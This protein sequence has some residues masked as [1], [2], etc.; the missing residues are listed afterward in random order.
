MGSILGQIWVALP[1]SQLAGCHRPDWRSLALVQEEWR[2]RASQLTQRC[3]DLVS[4]AHPRSRARSRSATTRSR[5]LGR[6]NELVSHGGA[7]VLC[8]V[9]AS[10][11][12][13]Y[14]VRC[15]LF[16][17][18]VERGGR[19]FRHARFRGR[20]ALRA[21]AR[22]GVSLSKRRICAGQVGVTLRWVRMVWKNEDRLII[23]SI[24]KVSP[25]C[26][27]HAAHALLTCHTVASG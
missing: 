11:E 10:I 5:R 13:N 12:R 3:R 27:W 26:R 24:I 23:A 6:A 16:G 15:D 14:S 17:C 9:G 21:T 20:S 8:R 18:G 7:L 1:D 4:R 19:W 2:G 22:G 25:T